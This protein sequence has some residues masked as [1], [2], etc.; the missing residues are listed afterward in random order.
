[1]SISD[2]EVFPAEVQEARLLINRRL[3][4]YTRFTADDSDPSCPER[5]REAIRYSLLSNGKRLRPLLVMAAAHVC[6]GKMENALGAAC[7]VEMIHTY[8]LIHDD[9]PAMDDDDLRRGK[10]TCHVQFDEA[11]AILAGDALLT[12]AFE[13]MATDTPPQVAAQCCQLLASAAGPRQLVGGQVEDLAAQFS[14]PDI[15]QLQRIHSRKTGALLT[16]SLELGGTIAGGTPEMMEA[17]CDY[18]NDI[19]L[20]F[21]IVDDL[22]DVQGE[23]SQLGKRTGKDS[24]HGKLT[25]PLVLGFEA[26]EDLAQAKVESA[27]S[28]LQV[29]GPAA[30][31]LVLFANFV[32]DRTR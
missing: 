9:L 32:V 27:I 30:E 3:D 22:L 26:S 18:G 23:E 31:P 17:L 7:A 24:E 16:V 4:Q 8:S 15:D 5:L 19:G 25:Y 20:A 12:M 21:Q 13:V 14:K 6:G 28:A 29:F 10:P 11:T 1:M 2:V